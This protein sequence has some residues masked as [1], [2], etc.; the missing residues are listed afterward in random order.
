MAS[1]SADTTKKYLQSQLD[2]ATNRKAA[3]DAEID[4]LEAA[5]KALEPK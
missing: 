3:I 4:G 2:K 5:L 1:R